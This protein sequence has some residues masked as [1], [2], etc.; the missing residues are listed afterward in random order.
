MIKIVNLNVAIEGK[1]ILSGFNLEIPAGEIHA[2]MGP[3][4]AGKSTL[5]KVLAGDPT[6][7]VL[8]GEIWMEECNILDLEPEERAHRG[9]FVGFQYPIE[10]P[11]ISNFH[12][13]HSARH[14]VRSANGK[15]LLTEEETQNVIEAKCHLLDYI[16]PHKVHV[17]INGQIVKTGGHE[18]AVAL[19]KKGYDWL[20]EPLPGEGS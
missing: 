8:S 18:L 19:E 6:Y 13:L 5:A 11:G 2:I 10:I 7:E 12:F 16:R 17:M 3:N 4:G 14:S 1:V 15:D 9:V 20:G